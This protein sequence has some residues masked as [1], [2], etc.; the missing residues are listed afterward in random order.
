M[1]HT[2]HTGSRNA[3]QISLLVKIQIEA[4]ARRIQ[5][6]IQRRADRARRH[7]SWG[8]GKE[9]PSC[10]AAQRRLRQINSGRLKNANG[11]A[12]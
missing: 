6:G 4:E 3:E 1:K 5:R 10:R 9:H 12:A 2:I 11:L 7:A 8:I